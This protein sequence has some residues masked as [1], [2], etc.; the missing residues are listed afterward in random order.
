MR[1]KSYVCC[2]FEKG[3]QLAKARDLSPLRL[4]LRRAQLSCRPGWATL[5]KR[6]QPPPLS[7]VGSIEP[8]HSNSRNP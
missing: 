3:R 6:S 5:P 4:K 7:P 8:L 2:L 1:E